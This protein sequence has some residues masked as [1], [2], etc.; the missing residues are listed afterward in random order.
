M[1]KMLPLT[2]PY[3]DMYVCIYIYISDIF[4]SCSLNLAT[5][6]GKQKVPL[7]TVSQHLST[8]MFQV[9]RDVRQLSV[10]SRQVRT[11]TFA[12]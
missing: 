6:V 11:D 4:S 2:R 7:T 9:K 3:N 5:V 10:L 8:A 1:K 12:V